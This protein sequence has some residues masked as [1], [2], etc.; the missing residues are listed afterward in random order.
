M[1]VWKGFEAE[2][3]MTRIGNGDNHGLRL[4]MPRSCCIWI[5][6]VQDINTVPIQVHAK[7]SQAPF[8]LN[9]IID[10]HI[11]GRP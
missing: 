11:T 9:L 4:E 5:P 1:V 8:I 6:P 3:F 7:T 2:G 10:I